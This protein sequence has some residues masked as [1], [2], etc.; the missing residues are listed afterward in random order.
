MRSPRLAH[1]TL[2]PPRLPRYPIKGHRHQGG[3]GGGEGTGNQGPSTNLALHEDRSPQGSSIPQPSGAPTLHP[4]LRRNSSAARYSHGS[5]LSSTALRSQASTVRSPQLGLDNLTS[6]SK[7]HDSPTPTPSPRSLRLDR[8]F[9]KESTG[10]PGPRPGAGGRTETSPR[11]KQSPGTRSM[12]RTETAPRTNKKPWG[13]CPGVGREVKQIHF[14]GG[15]LK[16][17]V[18]VV[19]SYNLD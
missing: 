17:V 4:Q 7:L 2:A 18:V 5:S 8:Y 12:P 11:A 15:R 16:V 1:P 10:W 3:G 13:K 9:A 6:H 14:L 19:Y